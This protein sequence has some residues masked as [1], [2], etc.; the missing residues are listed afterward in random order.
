MIVYKYSEYGVPNK[1]HIQ[2]TGICAI[3]STGGTVGIVKGWEINRE[4]E[5]ESEGERQIKW[6][7]RAVDNDEQS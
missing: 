3:G 7:R 5:K 2:H 1:K 4:Q 6:R